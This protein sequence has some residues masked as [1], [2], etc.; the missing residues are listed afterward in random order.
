MRHVLFVACD[1][2]LSNMTESVSQKAFIATYIRRMLYG[3]DVE[4]VWPNEA[5]V[6]QL[7]LETVMTTMNKNRRRPTRF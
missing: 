1:Q 2:F 4:S 6:R 7:M 3:T 5:A